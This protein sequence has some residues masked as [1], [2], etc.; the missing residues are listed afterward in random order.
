MNL[1]TK[2]EEPF[3]VAGTISN[4]ILIFDIFNEL[5]VYLSISAKYYDE[6]PIL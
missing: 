4:K 1:K 3:T 5:A 6:R 2:I